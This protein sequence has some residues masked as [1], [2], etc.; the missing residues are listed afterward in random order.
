MSVFQF[1]T[2]N[3]NNNQILKLGGRMAEGTEG[4]GFMRVTPVWPF[5][6]RWQ[7]PGL[8]NRLFGY[9]KPSI[10]ISVIIS[11]WPRL[12]SNQVINTHIILLKEIEKCIPDCRR[13]E[14]PMIYTE[15]FLELFFAPNIHLWEI[16]KANIS[17]IQRCS[18]SASGDDLENTNL[19]SFFTT[20]LSCQNM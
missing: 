10:M 7:T 3:P 2:R 4:R 13:K 1:I 20:G 8:G 16:L 11:S 17:W 5:T 15:M 19:L 6:C 18:W 9:K 12:H 14:F